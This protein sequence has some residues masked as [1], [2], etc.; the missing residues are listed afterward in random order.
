MEEEFQ[1]FNFADDIFGDQTC[2]QFENIICT[3]FVPSV[4]SFH[5]IANYQ[6]KP[7]DPQ[8]F[9]QITGWFLRPWEL[10]EFLNSDENTENYLDQC[11]AWFENQNI[12]NYI[13]RLSI[14]FITLIVKTF[15]FYS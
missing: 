15:Y 4:D 14:I 13:H 7:L 9:N 12:L 3:K 8:A 5:G 2:N 6:V 1:P 11:K 10:R